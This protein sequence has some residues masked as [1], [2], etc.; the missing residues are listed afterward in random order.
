MKIRSLF[1]RVTLLL[2]LSVVLVLGAAA[3]VMDHMVDAEMGQRFD[4][5][6]LTQARILASM[7]DVEPQGL[8]ME[9]VSGPHLRMLS[10]RAQV[11]WAVRCADGSRQTSNPA[12][13]AYPAGWQR[14]GS[15]QP[16]YADVTSGA[17]VFR[18]VWF[19]FRIGQDDRVGSEVAASGARTSPCTLLFMRSKAALNDVLTDIDAIVLVTPIV[20]LLMVLLASPWLV[21]RGLRPLAVLGEK[22]RS[23]GP[24][25]SG[26]R[27]APT[28]T[29]ELEPLVTRFNEVL[30]RM[31]EGMA[32]EREFAGALAH[33][34]RT[35]LAELRTLVDVERRYPSG[36]PLDAL[37]QEVGHISGELESIVA[38]LLLLTRLNADIEQLH[39]VRLNMADVVMRHVEHL[40]PIWQRRELNVT[41]MFYEGHIPVAADA[42]LLDIIV[43]N[44]LGNA[45]AYAPDGSTVQVR[46]NPAGVEISNFAP[47][48]DREDVARFGQRFWSKHH[49]GG[50]HAGLGLALA[51][52]AAKAMDLAL[53]FELDAQQQLRVRLC[54]TGQSDAMHKTGPESA[55]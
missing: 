51:G 34:T 48:L 23:I 3:V 16:A 39:M 10:G 38:G 4:A 26:N 36:R 15:A 29:R 30:S 14:S 6:L 2:V 18:A 20:A 50:N 49:A 40:A 37:L 24:Q 25:R 41:R 43:G 11:V 47:E 28:G 35:R 7:S 12:P 46:L 44:I 32:R 54:W 1:G 55:E 21:R 53:T 13:S 8:T 19:R 31:D 9:D 27:L 52:A 5:G 17:D 33:E 45:C 42:S 22:M